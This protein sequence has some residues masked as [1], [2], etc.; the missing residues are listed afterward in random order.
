MAYR[1]EMTVDELIV[2]HSWESY[3]AACF[4]CELHE[5]AEAMKKLPEW[6]DTNDMP[7][8][9]AVEVIGQMPGLAGSVGKLADAG[10][11]MATKYTNILSISIQSTAKAWGVTA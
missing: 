1:N 4:A 6:P 9:V 8:T 2:H 5:R 7:L 10:L 11:A 3:Y